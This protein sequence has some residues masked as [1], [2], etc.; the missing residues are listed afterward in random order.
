MELGS[1]WGMRQLND[2]VGMLRFVPDSYKN[3]KMYSDKA[4]DYYSYE[5]VFV[6]YFYKTQ[7]L[8]NEAVNIYPF[9]IKL[10]S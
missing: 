10:V 6:P 7:K 3:E 1:S 4:V 9:A 8:Y 5:L 2:A